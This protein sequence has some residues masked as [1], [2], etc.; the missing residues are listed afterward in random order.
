MY[1]IRELSFFLALQI[2]QLKNG[3]SVSRGK[4]LKDVLNKYGMEDAKPLRTHMTT[5]GHFG[6]G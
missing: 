6:F 3:T 5:N 4:Y 1:M 2:K